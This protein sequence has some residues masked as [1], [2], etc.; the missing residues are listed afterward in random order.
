[1]HLLVCSRMSLDCLTWSYL[2]LSEQVRSEHVSELGQQVLSTKSRRTWLYC[3]QV[4]S[5]EVKYLGQQLHCPL[6]NFMQ[7]QQINMA[8]IILH[9]CLNIIYQSVQ[10]Q[11]VKCR[12]QSTDGVTYSLTDTL[13]PDELLTDWLANW[14]LQAFAVTLILDHALISVFQVVEHYEACAINSHLAILQVNV[15]LKLNAKIETSS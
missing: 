15:D 7:R 11:S 6:T 10:T 4:R 3:E 5:V 8:N 12:H 1:M 13:I 14:L 2:R 9:K